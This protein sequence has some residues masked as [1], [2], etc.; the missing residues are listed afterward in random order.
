VLSALQVGGVVIGS[1]MT[2][3]DGRWFQLDPFP[4]VLAMP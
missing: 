3:L 4:G 1:G 2:I